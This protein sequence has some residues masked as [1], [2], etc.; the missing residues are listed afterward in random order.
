MIY[1]GKFSTSF[2]FDFFFG[3]DTKIFVV[4]LE[5]TGRPRTAPA[6]RRV[7]KSHQSIGQLR[8]TSPTESMKDN[9]SVISGNHKNDQHFY[10]FF[11]TRNF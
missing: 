5:N 8:D 4:S 10:M 3:L 11:L 1:L 6:Q 9:D 7:Y 2:F